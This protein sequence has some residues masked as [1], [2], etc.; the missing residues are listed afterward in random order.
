MQPFPTPWKHKVFWCFHWIEKGC[1]GNEWVERKAIVNLD[2]FDTLFRNQLLAFNEITRPLRGTSVSDKETFN[3]FQITFLHML[4]FS[5]LLMNR[6]NHIYLEF[7]NASRKICKPLQ[8]Q[9]GNLWLK[10][11]FSFC[12]AHHY[13]ENCKISRY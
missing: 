2:S 13:N 7:W 4:F 9:L 12:W 1:T 3:L 11:G 6:T 5:V 10:K 8:E